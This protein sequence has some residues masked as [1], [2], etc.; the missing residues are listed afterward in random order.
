MQ[1]IKNPMGLFF[2]YLGLSLFIL[3]SIGPFIWTA[4]QSLKTVKQA[5]A[6]TPLFIFE[7]TFKN[8]SDLWL[9]STEGNLGRVA[10]VLIVILLALIFIGIFARRLPLP[11]RA[12]YGGIIGVIILILWALPRFVDTGQFYDYFLNTIIVTVGVVIISISIGCLAGY[13]LARYNGIEGV[14]ILIAA[15]AFRSLPSM[16]LLLPFYWLGRASGLV[17]SYF[18]VILVLVAKNQ[19]FTIWLLSRFFM[20][21]P[22][23]IE[24][25]AMID[26][27]NRLTAFI[28]VI[29][30]IMWPGIISTALFTVLLAYHEFLLV[31]LLTT[32]NWTLPVAISTYAGGEDPGQITL[33]AAAAVST[34]IP[35]IFV[36]LFFQK[37]L[38]KGMT[39]GAVKG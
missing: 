14:V 15:L 5:T 26:G 28:K 33:A 6:R 3:Y 21:I 35:I 8:Y 37:Q 1:R 29:I 18:L 36:I 38:V 10:L 20:N 19:P 39:G 23:E 7:P 9:R 4:L 31:R 30:P 16:G 12:I 17:D 27:A 24:E 25:S 11:T 2:I 32:V 34:T 22:R 13:A